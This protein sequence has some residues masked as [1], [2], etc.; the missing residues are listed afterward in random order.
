MIMMKLLS[1][2]A[3]L[4]IFGHVKA[5]RATCVT[6]DGKEVCGQAAPKTC[7][8]LADGSEVCGTGGSIQTKRDT[9]KP[10]IAARQGNLVLKGDSVETAN[11]FVLT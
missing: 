2:G 11:D 5:Q 6:I 1:L 7:V 9:N 10:H 8:T 4:G 3:L